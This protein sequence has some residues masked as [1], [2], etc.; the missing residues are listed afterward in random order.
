M[1]FAEL[2]YHQAG[3]VDQLGHRH[4]NADSYEVIHVL[5]GGGSAL[6]RDRPYPL[7]PGTLLFIDA[8]EPH[9]VTPENVESYLRSKVIVDRQA[10]RTLLSAVGAESVLSGLFAPGGG[11]CYYL[12]A[13]QSGQADRLFGELNRA[14]EEGGR[15]ALR[16]ARALLG[17]LELAD[18]GEEANPSGGGEGLAPV[19]SWLRAHYAEN[20]T[21]DAV[22]RYAHLSKYHL[23][24]QFRRMT[25]VT[26]MG[27][28][29]ELRLSCA[30]RLLSETDQSISAIAQN[31][32][33]GSSS[34]FCTLFRRR[35][36]V[37]PRAYRRA[38]R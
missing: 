12:S 23:C 13:E 38:R 18:P 28:L 3:G 36:G 29:L 25:G 10:L 17:L 14:R 5:D 32:G 15:G 1:E 20:V 4:V 19:L 24:R 21:V 16:Q 30:R 33:F 35:E 2:A 34:H 37:S 8:S 7:L 11:A 26:L 9:C 27:Y 22:A 31:C 6:L